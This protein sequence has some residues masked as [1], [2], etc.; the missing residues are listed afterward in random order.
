MALGAV[1]L[2]VSRTGIRGSTMVAIPIFAEILGAKV[3][4]GIVLMLFVVGDGVAIRYYLRNTHWK[5]VFRLFPWALAGI[6][7]GALVGDAVS[8]TAFRRIMGSILLGS[9]LLLLWRELRERE[10]II[11]GTPLIS[12]ALGSAGG[13][14]SMV[15]NAA[16]PLMNLYLMSKG[17]NKEQFIGTTAWFF[18]LM[19]VTK[20]PFHFFLWESVGV[21]DLPL[22]GILVVPILVGTVLGVWIAK[23]LPEKPFRLV[24]VGLAAVASLRLVLF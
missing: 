5:T 18:F 23:T 12:A 7:I 4:A 11:P 13:F 21:G 15:G 9:A 8:D 24:V 19:N 22:V 20:L 6:V 3:S 10:L 17:Y 16:G 14:S 2:G 1:F